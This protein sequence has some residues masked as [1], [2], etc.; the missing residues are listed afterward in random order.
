MAGSTG[1]TERSQPIAS[2]LR[3]A[4]YVLLALLSPAVAVA[5]VLARGP[6]GGA[7]TVVVPLL[8]I[9][10]TEVLLVVRLG[11]L[12]RVAHRRA[13]EL[14]AHATA[15][16]GALHEQQALRDELTYRAL[17]DSLTGLGNRALLRERLQALT[18]RYGLLLLDLDG[19]KDVNDAYGHPVGDDLLIDVAGR[20][21]TVAGDGVLVRLGG[22]EFAILLEGACTDLTETVAHA[23]VDALRAPFLA[24]DRETVI[25]ASVGVLVEEVPLSP[26]EAL[27]RVDL[28]LYAAKGAGKNR[29]ERYSPDLAAE[30][31]RRRQLVADVRRGLSQ[32]EFAVH[33]QPV[34]D[35]GSGT[36]TAVEALV[37]WAPPGGRPVSPAE[38]IPVAEE[39]GLIVPLGA[40]GCCAGHCATYGAG[41]TGTAS[42]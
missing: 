41:M 18:G 5:T 38:F 19:F 2:P 36:V 14:D 21:R 7:G 42:R 12:A 40:P 37:R 28:A 16:S 20:L 33:Y 10:A 3:L 1:L 29:V 22:D 13:A 9:A 4:L 11:L 23:V 31:D 32:D 35:L 24:G 25:T 34:V 30:R 39:C 26:S 15:L 8:F 6:R 17:H 27:R